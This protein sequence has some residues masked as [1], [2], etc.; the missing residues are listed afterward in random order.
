MNQNIKK[1]VTDAGVHIDAVA[2]VE[3]KTALSPEAEE[4]AGLPEQKHTFEDDE[5]IR[6]LKQQ[7]AAYYQVEDAY[8][9]VKVED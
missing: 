9:E 2:S 3:V 6:Q 8:V 5:K 1:T 4:A 7:I